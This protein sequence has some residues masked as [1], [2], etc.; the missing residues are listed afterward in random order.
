MTDLND[1]AVLRSRIEKLLR[2]DL[3][4]ERTHRQPPIYL[5]DTIVQLC[6]EAGIDTNIIRVEAGRSDTEY[7]LV[8]RSNVG[9]RIETQPF[10]FGRKRPR[11]A[12]TSLSARSGS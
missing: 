2:S 7:V 4:K 10:T 9:G 1:Y 6:R 11:R 8:W 12:V 5:R 3:F